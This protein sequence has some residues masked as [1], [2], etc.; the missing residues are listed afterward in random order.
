ME[1]ILG[2]RQS[3][4]P[5]GSRAYWN[6]LS[7]GSK[8]ISPGSVSATKSRTFLPCDLKYLVLGERKREE[9]KLFL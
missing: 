1:Q 9:E 8:A 6:Y 7:E 4:C 5:L 2:I 3:E